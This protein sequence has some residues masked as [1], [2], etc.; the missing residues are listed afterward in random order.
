MT[1]KVIGASYIRKIGGRAVTVGGFGLTLAWIAIL[2]YQLFVL[3][4]LAI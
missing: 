2:G 3:I 4:K 1:T